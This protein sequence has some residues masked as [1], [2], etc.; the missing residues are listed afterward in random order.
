MNTGHRIGGATASG[1]YRPTSAKVYRHVSTGG[2][3]QSRSRKMAVAIRKYDDDTENPANKRIQWDK[4]IPGVD[5]IEPHPKFTEMFWNCNSLAK[6]RLPQAE[7]ELEAIMTG[8]FM[9]TVMACSGM[10]DWAN[11]LVR[12]SYK[13]IMKEREFVIYEDDLPADVWALF[14]PFIMDKALG[15][16]PHYRITRRRLVSNAYCLSVC[17]THGPDSSLEQHP[18]GH[19]LMESLER[20]KE[21]RRNLAQEMYQMT[22]T[23]MMTADFI[24]RHRF[25][26]V[27][28]GSEVIFVWVNPDW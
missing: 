20:E 4:P 10:L 11:K 17:F 2:T 21:F 1:V 8:L 9:N 24:E 7:K 27:R 18:I 12:K 22:T 15:T 23:D 16:N 6:S 25:D 26:S 19:L 14:P 28:N 5:V 13:K 3:G